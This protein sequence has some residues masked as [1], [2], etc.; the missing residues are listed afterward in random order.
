MASSSLRRD[1]DGGGVS[2]ISSGL[3]VLEDWAEDSGSG[4]G[5]RGRVAAPD[6]SLLRVLVSRDFSLL[7]VLVS[8]GLVIAEVVALALVA[9]SVGLVALLVDLVALLVAL[10]FLVALLAVFLVPVARVEAMMSMGR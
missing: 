10:L 8:R 1:E 2:S 9:F 7:R 6:W 3:T 4:V 5:S